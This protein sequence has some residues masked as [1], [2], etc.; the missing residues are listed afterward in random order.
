MTQPE[1]RK[2]SVAHAWREIILTEKNIGKCAMIV[3]RVIGWIV[4][5]AGL[6]VLV[7]DVIAWFNTKIWAPIA[8]GQLWYEL[9]RSSLNLVQAVT[10][11]YVSPF[12]WDRIIVN[13]L[14]C[15]AFAV[16][17]GLGGLILLLARKHRS[18][19]A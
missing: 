15:W 16:L 3:W 10:Q 2:Q 11:R 19:C 5:L 13:I 7:R 9:D 18:P 17:V 14:L 12:L 1:M 6:S 4:F 8:I